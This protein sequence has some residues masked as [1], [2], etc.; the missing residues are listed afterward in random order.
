MNIID[1]NHGGGGK[2]V[3]YLLAAVFA[4][5]ALQTAYG[6]AYW[7]GNGGNRNYST[8]ANWWDG[9][10]PGTKDAIVLF[11]C[12]SYNIVNYTVNFDSAVSFTGSKI[13]IDNASTESNPFVFTTGNDAHGMSTTGIFY[14]GST[15]GTQD[16]RRTDG[17]LTIKRGTYSGAA[18]NLG[19]SDRSYDIGGYVTIDGNSKVSLTSTGNFNIYKG[20]LKLD[21]PNATV[22]CRQDLLVGLKSGS[23]GKV[24]VN[25]GTLSVTRWITV[26]SGGTGE[27]V[28][29]G[30]T[31]SV[32]NLIRVGN[33]G[34][35]SVVINN[36]GAIVNTGSYMRLGETSTGTLTV[37]AGG[38]YENTGSNGN[39]TIAHGNSATGTL[40]VNGGSVVVK[41][42]IYL[43]YGD[44]PTKASVYVTNGGVIETDT[45]YK[46]VAN[47][48]GELT[49]DNGTIRHLGTI[50]N[51]TEL[52]KA[53]NGLNVYVGA[54]GATF[55]SNGHGI[56]I[57]AALQNKPEEVGAVTFTGGGT[58]TLSGTPSYTGGT[59]NVAGTVLS[60]TTEAKA[61]L[62]ANPIAVEIPPAG[63]A[64]GTTVLEINEGNGTFIQSEVDAIAVTGP[65]ASRYALVLAPGGTKVVISDTLAGEYV[66]N[67]GSSGAG[68]HTS[69]KWS[70]NGIAGDWYDSTAAFFRNA[71]DAATV[72]A[73]VTAASVTFGADATVGGT[74]T[75]TVPSVTVSNGV[76]A[77]ISAPTDGSLVKEGP[78][79]LTLRSSRAAQTDVAEGTLVMSGAG[80]TLDW[81]GVTLG[82]EAG[83]TAILKF[84][85]GATVASESSMGNLYICPSRN[86]GLAAELY[87][88]GG[89]WSLGSGSYN[90]VLA[91]AKNSTARFYHR[92][93]ALT[94]GRYV[95]IGWNNESDS[96]EALIEISGGTVA[97]TQSS[98]QGYVD[99]GGAG[100]PGF[101]GILSVKANGTFS[102]VVNLVV[103]GNGAG[104]LDIDGGT[105]SVANGIV[106]LCYGEGNT[107]GED[108]YIDIKNG[109]TLST[110]SIQYGNSASSHGAADATITFNDGTLR[111][112]QDGILIQSNDKLTVTVASGGG[113]IDANGKN[114]TIAEELAGVGG[115]TYKG[116]GTVTLSA[117]PTYSGTTTVEVGTTLVVP[118]AIAGANLSFAIPD[119]L[120]SGAYKVALVS[121]GG[122]FASDVLSSATLPSGVNAHFYLGNGDTEIWCAYSSN[123]SDHIW[124]GGAAGSLNEGANWLSGNVPDDGNAIIGSASAATLTN[125]EGSGFAAIHIIVPKDSAAVTISGDFSGITKIENYSTSQVEFLNA[126]T[127][128]ANVNVIQSPGIVKFTGGATG[129]KL[130]AATA[131]HGTY[132]FTATGDL[133]E[134]GG[135]TVKSDGVY[136]LLGGTFYK[137]NGDFHVEAGGKA[138]VNN[139]KINSTAKDGAHLLGTFNGLFVVTN[140]FLVQG[141]STHYLNTSGSGT[142]VVNELRVIQN[143]KIALVKA[144]VGPGGIVRGAGYVRVYNNG[145]CEYGSCDDWTMYHNSKG[146]NTSTDEPVFYK[147][148]SS[149][150]LSHLTFDT[151]DYY[152]SSIGR[153]ITCEAPIGAADAAS[154]GK[155]D[156]TVKGKGKFVFANTSD[157]N[158]FSGGLTVQDSAT[159][160]VMPNSWPGRGAVTLNGTSTLLLHTGGAAR[161]GAV[162]VNNGATLKV[163][164][165]GT[166]SLGGNLTLN[167][168]ATLA[169]NFTDKR[170]PPVLN[171]A[172]VELGVQ[173][174]VKVS[175]SSADGIRPAYTSGNE[176]KYA[177][178][179]GGAFA[180]KTV[181]FDVDAPDWANGVSIEDGEIVLSVKQMGTIF[182]VM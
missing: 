41:G 100:T 53:Q 122:A 87:K 146:T 73:A 141:D 111:A 11:R 85:G 17:W 95:R 177:L 159:V 19:T 32:A 117:A 162:T 67:D 46:N 4:F 149:S 2:V 154:A 50:G 54:N 107:A 164:E 52:I 13:A 145:S 24:E 72:D 8:A 120:A 81:S 142:L 166:V 119:G 84:E 89:D 173:K 105:A 99:V 64:D 116:S 86:D 25:D 63:V 153:T 169:F 175:L 10:K 136:N 91:E 38:R 3:S 137:H 181:E 167:D 49:I 123:A 101:R 69:G 6:Y 56:T 60:L 75:L 77:A 5:G 129:T 9:T 158:I 68:W 29:N 124:I 178:T 12:T 127:F 1:K 7:Y 76:S 160:E 65:D 58:I 78:G 139:A 74:A 106:M 43:C 180:D 102:T 126:V 26:G 179:S 42:N 121:G 88:D 93:G 57:S 37:N 156:V 174:S 132:N 143:G 172:G 15:N 148:S 165:S 151:T 157:G 138:V 82:T 112:T 94:L 23:T 128:A 39:M 170:T 16:N 70:K 62:V 109:G 40:N 152:D 71:G 114:V 59:T 176:G 90:M 155:F 47:G 182:L 96:G 125:P 61:A 103:G 168:G 110:K 36:G 97:H 98:G 134:I 20:L 18:F 135:T 131:I 31:M 80:T 104:T 92:G 140:Q 44:S 83:K 130:G 118:S 108:C 161:T 34:T 48:V 163:A 27:F 115:M 147:Q 22:S 144:I 51:S 35:G 171:L 21:N 113:T 150:T 33:G 133:T 45:I 55:D 28:V 30:S 66:W 14:I 79:T